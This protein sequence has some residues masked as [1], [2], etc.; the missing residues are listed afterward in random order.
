MKTTWDKFLNT[1]TPIEIWFKDAIHHF[2]VCFQLQILSA[3]YKLESDIS[4]YVHFVSAI[5][6]L[7]NT[8]F[9]YQQYFSMKCHFA[10]S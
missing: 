5:I 7:Y 9:N 4:F 1:M 2:L 10:V 3:Q 8:D 6:L